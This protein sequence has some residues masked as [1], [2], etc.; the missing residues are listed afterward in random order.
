[1]LMKAKS[2]IR[3]NYNKAEHGIFN[4]RNIVG[5]TMVNIYN[6][7]GLR[8]D[9]CPRYS[10]FEVFGLSEEEFEN[11]RE[12]YNNLRNKNNE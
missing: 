3:E 4:T 5:D 2:I 1:M 11:L 8:I 6:K 12:F 10:Y 9:I 7:E